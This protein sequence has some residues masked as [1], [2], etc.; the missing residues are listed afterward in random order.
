MR[1]IR[2]FIP[3]AMGPV[4]LLVTLTGCSDGEAKSAPKLP[5]RICW[6]IFSGKEVS[7]LLPPGDEVKVST[8]TFSLLEELDSATCSLY[9][10][11]K[12]QLQASATRRELESQIDWS[13]YEKGET[14]PIDVGEKGI[15]WP[16][17]A[18]AY[19]AC[20][21]SKTPSAPGNYINLSI[22]T[23]DTPDDGKARNALPA[24]LEKFVRFTQRE[25]QCT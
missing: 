17:G 9:V 24:L 14:D 3:V 6:D 1:A 19:V 16:G 23:F 20:E 12:I 15:I 5:G 4:L 21:P 18:V 22:D 10:D 7:P 25:L 11:G 8:G 2:K 13:S